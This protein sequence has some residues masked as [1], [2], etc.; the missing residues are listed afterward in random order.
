MLLV[1]EEENPLQGLRNNS[2]G[3]QTLLEKCIETDVSSVVL[4]STVKAVRLTNVMGASKRIAEMIVQ[5]AA[6]R[7]PGGGMGSVS[8]MCWTAAVLWFRCFAN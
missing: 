8:V 5:D 4:I 2:L 3:T 7:F 1:L 6:R